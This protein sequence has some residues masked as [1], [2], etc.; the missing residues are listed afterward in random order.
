M[1][2][3]SQSSSLALTEKDLARFLDK[4]EIDENGCWLWR[5]AR[6]SAN[7]H[8]LGGYARFWLNG[9]EELGHRVAYETFRGPIPEGRPL[10][11]GCKPVPQPACVNYEH[12]EISTH[13]ENILRGDGCFAQNARKTHCKRGHPFTTENTGKQKNGRYCRTCRREDWRRYRARQR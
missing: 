10:D 6:T 13:K 1:P 7:S 12:V 9:R 4:V 2:N 5:G 3:R 8:G 11:H